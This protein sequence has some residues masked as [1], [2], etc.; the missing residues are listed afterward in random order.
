MQSDGTA[1]K[2]G[3]IWISTADTES[4]PKIY[5][6]NGTTLKFVLL[7]NSDQ[8]TEDGVVFADARY[9]TAGANSDKAGTIASLLVSNFVDIDAPDPALYP[10]GMLL[11][12]LRRSGFNVKKFVRNHVNTATDN[13][14]FGDES[15]S[16]YYAHRWVTESANQTNGA[17]SFGR[18]AQRKVIVQALQACLLY[19][20]PSPRD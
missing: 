4:Y 19:T 8:T 7:D 3:D 5:K 14:R 13:I 20:S 18:K 10:K 17:G 9:N 6:Y 12:N 16:G 15:Q 1:L 11:Y 2:N